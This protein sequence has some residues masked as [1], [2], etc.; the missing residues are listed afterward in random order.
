[1]EKQ[2]FHTFREY[3]KRIGQNMT[4]S[5]EDYLEM[6]FRLSQENGY[7]RIHELAAALNV[8]PPAVTRMVQRLA[9]LKLIKYQKYGVLMLDNLGKEIGAALIGRHNLIEKFLKAIGVEDENLLEETEKIEHTVSNKTM[10]CFSAFVD[11]YETHPQFRDEYT[12]FRSSS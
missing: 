11:F 7:T 12:L 2:D 4:A 3:M 6:I 8:Q 5:M 9:E 10:E 1:V